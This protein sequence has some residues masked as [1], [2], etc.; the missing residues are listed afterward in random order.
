MKQD[1]ARDIM[2]DVEFMTDTAIRLKEL[3]EKLRVHW[4]DV[5]DVE[6]ENMQDDLILIKEKVLPGIVLALLNARGKK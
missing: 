4:R 1:V 3:T 5:G 2:R 6:F